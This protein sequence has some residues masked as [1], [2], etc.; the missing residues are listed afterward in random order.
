MFFKL[1]RQRITHAIKF[2]LAL[3]AFTATGIACLFAILF[4]KQKK[5]NRVCGII[6]HHVFS[7]ILNI[8]T[9]YIDAQK[10]NEQQNFTYVANHQSAYDYILLGRIFPKNTFIIGKKSIKYIP[11]LNIVYTWTGNFF[12]QRGNSEKARATVD[13]VITRMKKQNCSIL[14]FPQGT[15]RSHNQN[16][17]IKGGFAHIAKGSNTNIVPILISSYGAKDI[18][19]TWICKKPI[20][21]KVCDPI[22]HTQSIEEIRHALSQALENTIPQLDSQSILAK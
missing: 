20:L 19:N 22:S 15:R 10:I 16:T 2:I 9:E 5:T 18:L 14:I 6:M 17:T 7:K 12:I 1:G 21:I 4:F 3:L 11:L 8:K 13:D